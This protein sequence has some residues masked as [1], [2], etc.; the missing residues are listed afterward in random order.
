MKK[1]DMKK[2]ELK[3]KPN[4]ATLPVSRKELFKD[5]LK[6]DFSLNVDCG[7]LCGLFS[8]PLFAVWAIAYFLIVAA[9]EANY[10]TVFSV[11]FYCGLVCVPCFGIRYLAKGAVYQLYK[12]RAFN[13]GCFVSS[14]FW[15]AI[16][17]NFGKHFA[18]GAVVGV[19]FWLTAIGGV[20]FLVAA[21]NS[22][23][24]GLGVG[25]CLLQLIVVYCSTSF[26]LCQNCV[27]SLSFGNLLKNG[28]SFTFMRF[29]PCVLFF[30]VSVAL[31]LWLCT[32]AV[33]AAL[34]V[35]AVYITFA[36]SL[37]ALSA[38]LFA[39]GVFDKY[40]NQQNYPDLVGKGLYKQKE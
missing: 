22:V 5:V 6:D 34:I 36:E 3:V 16:R 8:L 12:K 14:A 19:S 15:Q 28:L 27:Y 1:N 13:E 9:A 31:P 39:H 2:K 29:V 26:L 35:L 24:K 32:L 11:C 20:Y 30:A 17:Q 38:T 37:F 7:L 23:A 33:W 4:D 25:I 40:I 21:S 18:A 10:Q